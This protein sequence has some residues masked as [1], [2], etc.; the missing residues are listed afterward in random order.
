[1]SIQTKL[2]WSI[3]RNGGKRILG[4]DEEVY[5]WCMPFIRGYCYINLA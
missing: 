1:M 5:V 3:E 4:K 2:L